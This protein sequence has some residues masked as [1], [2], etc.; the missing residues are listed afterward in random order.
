MR[1]S[2]LRG[3][4]ALALTFGSIALGCADGTSVVGGP[5][6]GDAS[7]DGAVDVGADGAIDA[8][9]DAGIDAGTDAGTDAAGDATDDAAGDAGDA[10]GDGGAGDAGD[11]GAGDAG[12]SRTR[13]HTATSLVS[14]GALLTSPN[15]RMV[16][17]LGQPSMLRSVLQSP[18]F[19]LRGGLVGASGGSR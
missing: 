14:A 18:N 10:A 7:A 5:D 1:Q 2:G 16:S 8:S 11:G 17:T 13:G 15:F 19:R 6:R 3:A 9:I 12:P 4:I